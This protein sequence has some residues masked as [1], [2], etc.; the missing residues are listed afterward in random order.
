MNHET[1]G[2]AQR[3]QIYARH[4]AGL[5]LLPIWSSVDNLGFGSPF[6]L[7]YH[8]LFYL[9]AAPLAIALGSLK[10]ADAVAVILALTTGAWG[11]FRLTRQMGAGELG[12]TV[13][14]ISLIAANYT[15][16]PTRYAICPSG[17][18]RRDKVPTTSR[19]WDP[20]EASK[21]TRKPSVGRVRLAVGV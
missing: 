17:R 13:A 21:R 8:R 9:V 12:A 6:P 10:A 15:A 16:I 19:P 3:T 20:R 7:F 11:M 5:D 18:A 1:W 2:I 14:G 4:V